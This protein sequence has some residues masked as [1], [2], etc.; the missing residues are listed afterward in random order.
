MRIWSLASAKFISFN[1]IM[2]MTPW[3][4]FSLKIFS[5]SPDDYWLKWLNGLSR[6]YTSEEEQKTLANA[7]FWSWLCVKPDYAFIYRLRPSPCFI[8]SLRPSL[9]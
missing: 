3:A 9:L 8:S 4:C 1:A 7:I 5:T 6:I 2:I